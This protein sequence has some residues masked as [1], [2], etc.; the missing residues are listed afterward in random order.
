MEHIPTPPASHATLLS[1]GDEQAMCVSASVQ[2]LHTMLR[3]MKIIAGVLRWLLRPRDGDP[4][5]HEAVVA[6]RAV[7]HTRTS[8]TQP[9]KNGPVGPL[10]DVSEVSSEK[11]APMTSAETGTPAPAMARGGWRRVCRPH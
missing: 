10:S 5:V 7:D 9:R 1:A 6:E 3:M 11:K 4:P 8:S 2:I